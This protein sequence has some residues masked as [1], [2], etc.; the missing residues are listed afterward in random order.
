MTPA[1]LGIDPGTRKVGF[2]LVTDATSPPLAMGIESLEAV[3]PTWTEVAPVSTFS[4]APAP[5]SK[6]S[7]RT[8]NAA[9]NAMWEKSRW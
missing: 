5:K 7:R 8:G 9:L 4:N 6:T 1:V 2:A 3:A